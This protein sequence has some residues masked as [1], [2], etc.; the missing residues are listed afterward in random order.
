M[1]HKEALRLKRIAKKTLFILSVLKFLISFPLLFEVVA[2][3]A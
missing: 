2:I 1:T 3:C